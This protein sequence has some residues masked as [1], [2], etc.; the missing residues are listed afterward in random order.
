MDLN[1]ISGIYIF[2]S[3]NNNGFQYKTGTIEDE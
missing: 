3:Y 1:G 2:I